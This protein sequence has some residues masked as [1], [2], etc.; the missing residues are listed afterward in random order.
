MTRLT[1]H[2]FKIGDRVQL[3][4]SG[5]M[6]N[7]TAIRD[8]IVTIEIDIRLDHGPTVTRGPWDLIPR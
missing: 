2:E 1:R 6:G 5:K 8:R 4:N 7:I 3:R